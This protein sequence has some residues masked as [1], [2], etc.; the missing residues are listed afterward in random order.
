MSNEV[1]VRVCRVRIEWGQ[2]GEDRV[3]TSEESQAELYVD[4]ELRLSSRS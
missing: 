3:K 4:D 2:W 1:R